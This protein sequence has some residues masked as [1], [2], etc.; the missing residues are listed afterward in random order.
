[1]RFRE[2]ILIFL[3]KLNNHACQS[4]F[5]RVSDEFQ[6]FPSSSS[7]HLIYSLKVESFLERCRQV[8]FIWN[9]RLHLTIVNHQLQE[10]CTVVQS[11]KNVS[12]AKKGNN[13][14]RIQSFFIVYMETARNTLNARQNRSVPCS[15]SARFSL[16]RN[17]ESF[18]VHLVRET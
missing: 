17:L 14:F 10:S 8:Q 3:Y 15:R 1:M 16:F 5:R 9:L 11:G 12:Y 18:S 7:A 2:L 6:L 4:A 13:S